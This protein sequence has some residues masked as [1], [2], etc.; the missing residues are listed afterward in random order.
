VLHLII[1]LFPE[2]CPVGRKESARLRS[3]VLGGEGN[4]LHELIGGKVG[5]PSLHSVNGVEEG[6]SSF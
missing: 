2:L 1:I 5:F 3:L 6:G 4:E